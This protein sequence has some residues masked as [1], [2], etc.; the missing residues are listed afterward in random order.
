M[1]P[2]LKQQS[3]CNLCTVETCMKLAFS[4]GLCTKHY[5]TMRPSLTLKEHIE[6]LSVVAFVVYAVLL[7]VVHF[8]SRIELYETTHRTNLTVKY[9]QA[10]WQ[11]RNELYECQK[12]SKELEQNEKILELIQELKTAL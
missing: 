9:E 8:K 12:N 6:A 10:D 1:K 3:D 4:K 2:T 11:V 7:T 5:T